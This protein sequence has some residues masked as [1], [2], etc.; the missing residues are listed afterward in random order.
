MLPNRNIEES[1][2]YLEELEKYGEIKYL[3]EALS[4]VMWALSIK[5]EYFPEIPNTNIRF[6]RTIEFE[7]E[8]YSV[9][10]LKIWFT[11]IDETKVLLLFITPDTMEFDFDFGN[12]VDDD[13]P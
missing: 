3:D 11:I 8:G 7:R 1:P 13:I 10:P 6:V 9:V 4:G 5:P 12:A 2:E